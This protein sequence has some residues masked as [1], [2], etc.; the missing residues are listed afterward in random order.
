MEKISHGVE[1]GNPYNISIEKKP[2][3]IET[4][5]SNYRVARRVYQQ[6]LLHIPELFLY[7]LSPSLNLQD[8][9]EDIKS[10]IWGVKKITDVEIPLILSICFKRFIK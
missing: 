10:N 5:E 6:L 3:I 1:F 2:E 8:M 4:V 9:D 7:I